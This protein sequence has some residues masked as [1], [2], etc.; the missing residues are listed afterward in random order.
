[1]LE[2][3]TKKR[4]LFSHQ[5]RDLGVI[6]RNPNRKKLSKI[7]R[8]LSLT[9]IFNHLWERQTKIVEM[10]VYLTPFLM[11]CVVMMPTRILWIPVIVKR[12][13]RPL[14]ARGSFPV[15]ARCM[16]FLSLFWNCT[17]A[18]TITLS[19]VSSIYRHNKR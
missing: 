17:D 9:L 5:L 16:H 15:I 18:T 4:Q 3:F 11:I 12:S 8:N 2:D 19:C 7:D 14:S 6:T 1:M 10:S 13:L